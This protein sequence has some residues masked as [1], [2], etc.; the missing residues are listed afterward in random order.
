MKKPNTPKNAARVTTSPP[1]QADSGFA[2]SRAYF[3]DLVDSALG[4]AKKLGDTEAAEQASEGGGLSV[5]VRKR[6][7]DNV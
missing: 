2:Y 6:E 7:L 3:E 5:S 1:A 4:H